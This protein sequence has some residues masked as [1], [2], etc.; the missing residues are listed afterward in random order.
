MKPTRPGQ[1]EARIGGYLGMSFSALLT[2]T[3][4]EYTEFGE[5]YV[6]LATKTFRPAAAQWRALE[7]TLDDVQVW[8]W[9]KAYLNPK[10]RD[11]TSWEFECAWGGRKIKTGGSNAFP[12]DDDPRK[13]AMEIES[14]RF[15]RFLA[16]ISRLL[17]GEPFE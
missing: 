9:K 17:G 1:F 5:Q 12:A 4:L 6:P 11:G 16:A 10:V 14:P 8:H 13:T 3:G 7:K 2:G 15:D